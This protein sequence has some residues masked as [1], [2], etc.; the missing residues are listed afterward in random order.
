[1]IS[2]IT[3]PEDQKLVKISR[4]VIGESKAQVTIIDIKKNMLIKLNIL[5]KLYR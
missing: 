3:D 4:Y 5:I 2:P 1:M